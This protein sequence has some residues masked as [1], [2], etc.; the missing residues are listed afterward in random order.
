VFEPLFS[1]KSKGIG[2]GLAIS[3]NLVQANGGK[4]FVKSELGSGTTF[5]IW[6]Q[7]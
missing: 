2:L 4:I 7:V 6:L 3:K 5:T 1:T